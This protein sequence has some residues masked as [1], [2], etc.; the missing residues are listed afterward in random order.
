MNTP[1]VV[2][3]IVRWKFVRVSNNSTVASASGAPWTSETVPRM[4]PV[5]ACP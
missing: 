3:A 4:M 1:A 2:V 5:V